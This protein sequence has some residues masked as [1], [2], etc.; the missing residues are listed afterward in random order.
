MDLDINDLISS[1]K[2][3]NPQKII[4]FGSYAYG[5]PNPDSDIDLLVITDTDKSFHQRIQQLRPLL[6]KNRPIDLI[7]LTPQEYQKAQGINPLVTEIDS[8]GKVLYG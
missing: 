2:S 8:K 1:V 7:V 6:P 3:T 5:T 4:L